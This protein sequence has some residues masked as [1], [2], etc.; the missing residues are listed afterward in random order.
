MKRLFHE[1]NMGFTLLEL[2]VTIAIVS[3]LSAILAPQYIR[4]RTKAVESANAQNIRNAI[5]QAKVETIETE[6]T[7]VLYYSYDIKTA[8]LTPDSAGQYEIHA[9][10]P[11]DL[12]KE[13]YPVIYV[14]VRDH[15]ISTWPAA[16]TAKKT[17]SFV[18][19]GADGKYCV[20]PGD[21][22]RI[23]S[24]TYRYIGKTSSTVEGPD[25]RKGKKYWKAVEE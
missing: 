7:E 4:Y 17:V 18:T 24:K 6:E 16:A 1:N 14:V 9:G 10:S 21:T 20:A 11:C 13:I 12:K 3:V 22:I 5:E 8:G 23:G 19:A 25:T 15:E 2:I